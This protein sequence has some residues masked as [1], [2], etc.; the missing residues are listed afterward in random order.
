MKKA[1]FFALLFSFLIPEVFSQQAAAN[2][3]TN[4]TILTFLNPGLS[5]EM[6]QGKY[7]SLFF[8]GDVSTISGIGYSSTFGFSAPFDWDPEL[9]A[10]YRFYYN[11]EKRA[12]K[13]KRTGAKPCR[14]QNH[15]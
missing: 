1:F 2:E 11:G 5:Y 7:Q 6:K 8:R 9:L 4:V 3:V 10:N 12:K 13:G 15:L 14:F